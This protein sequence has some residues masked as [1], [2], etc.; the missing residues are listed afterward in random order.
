MRQE[1][2]HQPIQPSPGSARRWPRLTNRS[3]RQF[4]PLFS[5]IALLICWQLIAL[6]GIYEAFIIPPP[7]AVLAK[8]QM[9]LLNGTLWLHTSTTLYNIAIGLGIGITAGVALGYLIAKVPLLEDLLS[10]I[11]V[12]FQS[13]PVVAYAPL[14][15]IWFGSGPTSKIITC[16]LIVFFPMLMNTIIGIR[17]VSPALRDLMRS[18]QATRWQTF[19]KLEVPAAMPVLLAGLKISATLAVIG[20]VV[21]EFIGAK[22]GLGFWLNLA[23]SQYDTPLV[24]VSI[25]TLAVIARLLYSLVTLLERYALRWQRRSR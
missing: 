5:L 9:V 11:I 8:F 23:R 7:S 21:G 24:V 2:L 15:V 25:L 20:A 17:T 3:L 14:L 18:M 12:A 10:P 13:T 19:I 1:L 6:S 22:A 4:A 16:A